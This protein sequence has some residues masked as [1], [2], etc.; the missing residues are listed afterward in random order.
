MI[1]FRAGVSSLYVHRHRYSNDAP[2][3]FICPSCKEEDEDEEHFLFRCPAYE[4]VRKRFIFRVF[5]PMYHIDVDD[6][7]ASDKVDTIRSASMYL[8]HAF[9]HRQ[10]A[11]NTTNE[12]CIC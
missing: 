4:E 5:D 7:L 12:L 9:R 8:F 1:R 3:S 6:I 11:M 2:D 10:D